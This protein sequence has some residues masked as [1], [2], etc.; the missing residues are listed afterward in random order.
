MAK[1][2]PQRMILS[3]RHPPLGEGHVQDQHEMGQEQPGLTIKN[4][5]K[6]PFDRE[7]LQEHGNTPTTL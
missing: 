7:S 6:N 5:Q 4:Q 2:T 3:S 1:S